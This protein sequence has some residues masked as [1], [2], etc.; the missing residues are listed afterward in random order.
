MYT[1][2]VVAPEGRF[3]P[4]AKYRSRQ[5]HSPAQG[6]QGQ[7]LTLGGKRLVLNLSSK[8]KDAFKQ[9]N[10]LISLF[11]TSLERSLSVM[12]LAGCRRDRVPG[13]GRRVLYNLYRGLQRFCFA[14][15]LQANLDH[16]L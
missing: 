2:E 11:T 1:A 15:I 5:K 14:V 10:K 4:H 7:R 8:K 3:F 6:L 16:L 12:T 9:E 13:T